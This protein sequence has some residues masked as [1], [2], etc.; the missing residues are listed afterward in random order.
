MKKI[1]MTG[2]VALFLSSMA[3]A[4]PSRKHIEASYPLAAG[5]KVD[6]LP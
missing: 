5:D 2:A 3:T 6:S 4:W 1:L